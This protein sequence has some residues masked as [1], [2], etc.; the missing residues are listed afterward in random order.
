LSVASSTSSV[1]LFNGRE[2]FVP[3]P[4]VPAD[5]SAPSPDLILAERV[6]SGDRQAF[7]ILMRRFDGLLYRTAR[8][9]VTDD[10]DAEDVLQ[11]AFLLAYRK[12]SG[13]RGNAK[14]S[15]WLVRIVVNEALACARKRGQSLQL[16]T[17]DT[18]ALNDEVII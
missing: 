17:M 15:T 11:N 10:A 16:V 14:L 8:S 2:V 6:A 3:D 5:E 12:I 4:G 9:I 13:F 7:R 1:R 18:E